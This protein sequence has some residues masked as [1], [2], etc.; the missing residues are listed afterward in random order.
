LKN[1]LCDRPFQLDNFNQEKKITVT[2]KK[3]LVIDDENDIRKLIKTCLEIMGGWQVL[4]AASGIEGLKLA[5]IERPNA[6]LLDVMMPDVDGLTTLKKLQSN[7]MTNNIPV[8]LL[9][10]RKGFIDRQFTE[11]GIKGVLT[12]P[13][14]PLKI[15]EQVAAALSSST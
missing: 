6:I 11:L 8:I 14:N 13:F 9:T 4:T 7:S 5:Q 12:K 10:A 2:A 3:I 15:A 1:K